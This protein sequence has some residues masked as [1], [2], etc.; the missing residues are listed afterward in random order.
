MSSS[1]LLMTAISHIIELLLLANS[2]AV[3]LVEKVT[4]FLGTIS[5]VQ[6][7][8]LPCT[9]FFLIPLIAHV[10]IKQYNYKAS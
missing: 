6:K 4:R 8:C 7:S 2:S 3:V 1:L 10:K 5:L 9:Q